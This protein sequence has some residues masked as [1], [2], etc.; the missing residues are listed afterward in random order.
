MAKETATAGLVPVRRRGSRRPGGPANPR[1][2]FSVGGGTDGPASG[3]S[4]QGQFGSLPSG[5]K[6]VSEW[7]LR[8]TGKPQTSFPAPHPSQDFVAFPLSLRVLTS[9][10]PGSICKCSLLASAAPLSSERGRE[11]GPA[12]ALHT[13]TPSRKGGQALEDGSQGEA[14]GGPVLPLLP[15]AGE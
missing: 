13:H 9:P 2:N 11:K 6:P 7:P 1:G 5:F 8:A 15:V 4:W 3:D 12:R 10:G 14:G